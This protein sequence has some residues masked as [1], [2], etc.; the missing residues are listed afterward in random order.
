[1]LQILIFFT[2]FFLCTKFLVILSNPRKLRKTQSII[3]KNMIIQHEKKLSFSFLNLIVT[4]T[5]LWCCCTIRLPLAKYEAQ[6]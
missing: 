5:N 2:F 1:M 6:C 3:K 4:C